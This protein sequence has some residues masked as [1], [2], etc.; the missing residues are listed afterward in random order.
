MAVTA[1]D[2]AQGL[3]NCAAQFAELQPTAES[4]SLANTALLCVGRGP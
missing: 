2:I 3:K 4:M 1:K